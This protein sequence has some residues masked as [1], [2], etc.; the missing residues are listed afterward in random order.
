MD[1]SDED[2]DVKEIKET[3]VEITTYHSPKK[4][5]IST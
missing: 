4:D 3:H 2:E 5:T 1:S